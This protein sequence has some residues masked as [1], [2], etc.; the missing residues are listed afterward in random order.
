MLSLDAPFHGNSVA[1]TQD[2]LLLL[3]QQVIVDT[4]VFRSFQWCFKSQLL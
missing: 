3:S 1:V 2:Y 4:E